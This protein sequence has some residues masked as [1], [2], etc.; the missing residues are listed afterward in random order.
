M[1]LKKKKMPIMMMMQ[2]NTQTSGSSEGRARPTRGCRAE[3][4]R[5]DFY[6]AFLASSPKIV[7]IIMIFNKVHEKV[8][9]AV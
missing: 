2:C 8:V 3:L 7:I 5:L 6:I 9:T 1:L 4:A